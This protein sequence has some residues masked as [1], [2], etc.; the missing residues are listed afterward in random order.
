MNDEKKKLLPNEGQSYTKEKSSNDFSSSSSVSFVQL[1][2]YADQ[3]DK[4][5]L[6]VG[7]I[8]SVIQGFLFPMIIYY[9]GCL[10]GLIVQEVYNQCLV[11]K[12]SQCPHGIEIH[13][14]NLFNISKFCTNQNIQLRNFQENDRDFYEK[15]FHLA[16]KLTLFACFQFLVSSINSV[17]FM[18]SSK[19]Q[20]NRIRQL[21][22]KKIINKNLTY[23][24]KHSN[25]EWFIKLLSNIDRISLGIGDKLSTFLTTSLYSFFGLSICL[26]V[27]WPLA[28]LSFLIIFLN[29]ILIGYL[30]K[31]ILEVSIEEMR[32]YATAGSVAQEGLGALRTVLANNAVGLIINRYTNHLDLIRQYTIK[33]S[34]FVGLIFSLLKIML[35]LFYIICLLTLVFLFF[36]LSEQNRPTINDAL[37]IL[38]MSGICLVL[39]NQAAASCVFLSEAKAAAVDVFSILDEDD[40][41]DDDEERELLTNALF[42]TIE[43]YHVSFA[44]PTRSNIDAL[45][46]MNLSFERGKMIALVGHSGSGKSSCLQLLTRFYQVTSGE[47]RLDGTNIQNY[48]KKWLRENIAMV[49]QDTAIFSTTIFHN[50]QY[51]NCKATENDVIEAAKQANAHSFIMTLPDKYE[52]LIGEKGLNL[53]G[54][55]RQRIVLARALIQKAPILLLDEPT[56]ALDNQSERLFQQ[57]LSQLS[58]NRLILIVAHR[59]STIRHCSC[60]YVLE[61]GEILE[62]GDHDTLVERRGAYFRLIQAQK[63]ENIETI[64]SDLFNDENQ[65]F[66]D[67]E[68]VTK[69]SIESAGQ[70]H[71]AKSS[72]SKY[73][74]FTLLRMAHP[75]LYYI[76]LGSIFCFIYGG[77][78]VGFSLLLGYSAK[79][80]QECDT[81]IQQNT[82][83][84][85]C[86]SFVFL[87]IM[88]FLL[89]LLSHLN[90][91]IAGASF[92]RRL[93]IRALTAYFQQEMDWHDRLENNSAALC[94]RLCTDADDIKR[95]FNVRI[96]FVL[97]AAGTLLIGSIIG[98]VINWK[99]MFIVVIQLVIFIIAVVEMIS[100]TQRHYIK[101]NQIMEQATTLVVECLTNIRV[102]HQLRKTEDF[103]VKYNSLI[104][105]MTIRKEVYF[106]IGFL[107]GIRHSIGR[108]AVGILFLVALKLV[109]F[110]QLKLHQMIV[111]F[112]YAIYI[113][114]ATTMAE[115][116]AEELGRTGK[117]AENFV[118]LFE[119]QSPI[120][121]FSSNGMKLN[122]FRGQINFHQIT[123]SYPTRT[124]VKVL[125][126]FSLK[127]NPREKIGLIGPS[128]CGKSSLVHLL[129][130]FYDVDHGQLLIDN[131]EIRSLDV[132]WWRSQLSLVNQDP[133]VFNTTIRENLLFGCSYQPDSIP[134][135]D[136]IIHVAKLVNLHDF[137]CSLPNGYETNVG[138][139]GTQ[140]SGGQKQRIVIARAL[141][142]QTKCVIFDEA[143]SALDTIN[144]QHLQQ[145]LEKDGFYHNSTVIIIAHRLSTVRHCDVIYVLNNQGEII[146]SGTHETL[147]QLRG[148][149]FHLNNDIL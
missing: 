116:A 50:I 46:D 9:M 1:F 134:T 118:E 76:L 57:T 104:D 56:S 19:R 77:L 146:E 43:F 124:H 61:D 141:L 111:V 14:G 117:A 44:Y 41:T 10:C 85:I 148:I 125:D 25:C 129:L 28:I 102:V 149:Y 113:S 133:A 48:N 62:F 13:Y 101:H 7:L 58:S 6:I 138:F 94:V 26:F 92:I 45:K 8:S 2:R 33:K 105:Q 11:L 38:S 87:A 83:K 27:Y 54:G 123:F 78:D 81:E 88:T 135:M 32:A 24:D 20:T 140:L 142:R 122:S 93:R 68:L 147:L 137:I 47:I 35:Y 89:N 120:E 59:L 145:S 36:Q 37:L 22:F 39:I 95:L 91:A 86:L 51:G 84:W 143:T 21:L 130:R 66:K 3:L 136:Q 30:A 119:R 60:I 49:N 126:Q 107:S 103:S 17:T 12:T 40:S 34:V 29:F 79:T 55:E 72:R 75:E 112:G 4:C 121:N 132:N 97:Q 144:E 96:V 53:S 73:P 109:D 74:M 131:N 82:T 71:H 16:M 5:L 108:F 128:G 52:T 80:F 90:L 15:I 63:Q 42:N 69:T 64:Q 127:I 98:F 115:M 110:Q 99:L 114:F 18:S 65:K 139:N 100:I 70:V 67:D 23:F 31:V 106:L